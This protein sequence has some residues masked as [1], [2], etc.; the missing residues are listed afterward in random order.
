MA[1]KYICDMCSASTKETKGQYQHFRKTLLQDGILFIADTS[2]LQVVAEKT[3]H[4]DLCQHCKDSILKY[5]TE[6]NDEQVKE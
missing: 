6:E 4:V 2:Y 1:T 3:L 5:G